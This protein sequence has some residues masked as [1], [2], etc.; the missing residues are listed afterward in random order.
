MAGK[1]ILFLL[2]LIG[3]MSLWG[4]LIQ[5]D[6]A[7]KY[8]PPGEM[9][10]VG[11]YRMHLNCQGVVYSESRPTVVMEAAELSTNWELVQPEV[12]NFTRVCSYDRA[13]LGW[14]ERGPKLRTKGNIVA[15]LHTLLARG[16]VE[17]PYLLVG[18]S[19]GGMYVRLYANEYPDEVAGMV[20]VDAAH[21]SQEARF[22]DAITQLNQDG[23]KQTVW[24][25][26]LIR[27][28]NSFGTLTPILKMASGQLLGTV[29]EQVR[30]ISLAVILSDKFFD[31]VR[32]ETAVLEAHFAE[33]QA[34]GITS[35]GEIPLVVLTA[36]DQFSALEGRVP[37][38]DIE[39]LIT[40]VGELQGELAGLS[41]NGKLVDVADSGHFI[42]VDQPQVVID[43]IRE[44]VEAVRD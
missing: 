8:P 23:R 10:D 42:Q 11:G 32:E 1:I 24:L 34:V 12:A 27:R 40:V 29:P 16:G 38:G 6:L 18:H 14:S 3:G 43:V 17:P 26:G 33:I 4:M 36:V 37:D 35:L 21:E 5:K 39:E 19:K 2:L 30:E 22:P 9:V 20:L 7:T 15:E 25:L 28:L 44:V 41:P 13:G 31:T